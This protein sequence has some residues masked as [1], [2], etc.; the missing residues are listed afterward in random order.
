[1]G[2]K[3]EGTINILF[4]SDL[5]YGL[6]KIDDDEIDYDRHRSTREKVLDKL[7]SFLADNYKSSHNRNYSDDSFEKIDVLAIAGDI[8]WSGKK[9]NYQEF[10]DN[11]LIKLQEYDL[12]DSD[13]IVICMGNHDI[14]RSIA[15]KH[16]LAR[17]TAGD[18]KD[19][20]DNLNLSDIQTMRKR[21]KHFESATKAF[22]E[23]GIIPLENSYTVTGKSKSDKQAAAYVYGYRQPIPGVHFIVLNSAWD[24]SADD[25][26]PLDATKKIPTKGRLRVGLDSYED[27]ERFLKNAQLCGKFERYYACKNR[28][29]NSCKSCSKRFDFLDINDIFVATGVT[30]T[31]FHHPFY[32]LKRLGTRG[33]FNW[34]HDSETI[35]DETNPDKNYLCLALS[36][37]TDIIFNGHTHVTE[38]TEPFAELLS[39]TEKR[40]PA[41]MSGALYSNDTYEF[42]CWIISLHY[43]EETKNTTVRAYRGCT[44]RKLRYINNEWK[45]ED[46]L[47]DN[48][49]RFLI[50]TVR[51][52]LISL[53]QGMGIYASED[54]E[55][56]RTG[57]ITALIAAL[58]E[59]VL[60]FSK[61]QRE[62]SM[63]DKENRSE[64]GD[65]SALQPRKYRLDLAQDSNQLVR[66]P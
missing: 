51:E 59:R 42:G 1:M 16:N 10:K 38:S 45:S 61:E 56:A 53:L 5:H 47:K 13:K 31:M 46:Y 60:S 57:D 54:R 33:D 20:P 19:I 28:A 8:G 12:I 4:I 30:I 24:H 3:R 44:A 23:Y 17:P 32:P 62:T 58:I 29:K 18:I 43:V 9:K 6:C 7:L 64:L 26:D 65:S 15:Q 40:L 22:A 27:A 49:E 11:F 25:T 39:A 48:R 55:L 66:R 14:D 41:F 52:S 2:E 21:F 50:K 35:P 34:L 36:E 37:N 63:A